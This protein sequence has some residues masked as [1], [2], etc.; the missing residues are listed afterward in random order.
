M[1]KQAVTL[2]GRP[3]VDMRAFSETAAEGFL[4]FDLDYWSGKWRGWDKVNIKRRD[5]L[6]EVV[7][8]LEGEVSLVHVLEECEH[9]VRLNLEVI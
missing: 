1:D 7:R 6:R 2:S 9:T 5:K 4:G 3:I 8:K